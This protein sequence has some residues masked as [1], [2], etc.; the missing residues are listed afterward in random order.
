M[1]VQGGMHV[2]RRTAAERQHALAQYHEALAARSRALY[3][4][5]GANIARS[6]TMQGVVGKMAAIHHEIAAIHEEEADR[7]DEDEDIH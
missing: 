4:S 5:L 7:M 1:P 3:D 6:Q 2:A